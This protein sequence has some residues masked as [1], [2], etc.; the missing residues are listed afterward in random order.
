MPD[1]GFRMTRRAKWSIAGAFTLVV[2]VAVAAIAATRAPKGVEVRIEPVSRRDLVA[3]VTASG[4]V[5]PHTKVD[6]SADISGRIITLAV[7]E[8][9]T[10]TKG[11]LLVQIDP[12]T[13]Q[14]AVERSQAALAGAKAQ[15]IQA[16]ANEL[17]AER[18][19][20][21]SADIRK[22]NAQLVSDE[23]LEQLRTTADVGKATVQ[24]SQFQV[25]QEAAALRDDESNLGK[26]TIRAPMSGKVTRLAVEQ[27]ETA[28]QGTLNKDAATLLTISDMSVLETKVKVDET[29]VA[30]IQ[31]GDS[32]VVQFDAFPDTTFRGRVTK[33]ANSS[34]KTPGAAAN[35][36]STDQAVDYEVTIQLLNPPADTRPDFSATAKV[37]TDSRAHVLSIPIIALTVRENEDLPSSDSAVSLGK[38]PPAKQVGKRDVEGVFVVGP[39]RKV[40]F[41]PVKVG[42]AGDKYFEVV[43]G[44]RETE[45]I[46]GG[47][48]QAIR[49]LKDGAIIREAKPDSTSPAKT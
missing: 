13:Y 28:I 44:L 25:E 8:G 9:Q 18:N 6:M 29:D 10:V 47:T 17:Q 15:L 7:K 42:I 21:R 40:T 41:R 5:Q 14:A 43:T 46:V 26:T 30:H 16:Q 49:E 31:L 35:V 39:D 3:S 34:M 33:I 27:G 2:L 22:A 37:I 24:A 38:A 20:Q 19:Y 12:A 48:Y 36:T 11:Q 32:A 45:R 4:Q 23:Q 1:T